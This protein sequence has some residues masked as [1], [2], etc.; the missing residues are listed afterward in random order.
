MSDFLNCPDHARRAYQAMPKW[1]RFRFK[2][3]S[4]ADFIEFAKAAYVV[5][6]QNKQFLQSDAM[7]SMDKKERTDSLKIMSN[8]LRW[9]EHGLDISDYRR[10]WIYQGAYQPTAAGFAIR[11]EKMAAAYGF[12]LPPV[13]NGIQEQSKSLFVFDTFTPKPVVTPDLSETRIKYA[14]RQTLNA[15]IHA[16]RFHTRSV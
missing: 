9:I 11:I 2:D 3:Y 12:E 8:N 16:N 6:A 4:R 10:G 7:R 1:A 5:L 13:Q 15:Y 14:Y